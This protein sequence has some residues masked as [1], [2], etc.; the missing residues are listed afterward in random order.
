[1]EKR[2]KKNKKQNS[3]VMFSIWSDEEGRWLMEMQAGVLLC[4]MNQVSL[5]MTLRSHSKL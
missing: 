3:F 1:M 4:L 5:D 2:I